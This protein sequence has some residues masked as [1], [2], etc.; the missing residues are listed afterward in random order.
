M[1]LDTVALNKLMSEDRSYDKAID[2]EV[3]RLAAERPDD[4]VVF[5]SRLAWH[6]AGD[7]LKLFTTVDPVVA[8]K[9]I[10]DADRGAEERYESL[11]DA[12]ANLR[13]RAELERTRFK[14]IYGVDYCDYA[15]FDLIMDTTWLE[16]SLLVSLIIE[17]LAVFKPGRPPKSE[18]LLSP[19]SVYP[20]KPASGRKSPP[21]DHFRSKPVKVVRQDGYHLA[22][23][24]PEALAS[25]Q[26][27][28]SPY[29]YAALAESG[30]RFEGLDPRLLDQA[31]DLGGFVYASR[32]DAYKKPA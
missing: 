20:T 8:A 23:G 11:E 21:A 22:V 26:A 25:A 14:E 6:F 10:L 16:P 28:G 4:P 12:L 29:V 27:A 1:G 5:D 30:E 19:R 17:E 7:S 9:R 3:E 18:I 31:Q 2:L 32:P 13:L 24:D 15:N